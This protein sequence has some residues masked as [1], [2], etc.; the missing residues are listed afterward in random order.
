[1]S[2]EKF[3]TLNGELDPL[4]RQLCNHPVYSHLNDVD[5]LKCFMEQ[6]V[7]AV[8]DFMSLLKALQQEYCRSQVPWVPHENRLAARLVNEIVLAEESDEGPD[9]EYVSHFGM[10]CQAMK[11]V[12]ASTQWID[13]LLQVV[14]RGKPIEV[15][16]HEV[17]LP[18]HVRDFVTQTFAV[19]EQGQPEE[20]AAVFLFGREDLIPDMFNQIVG[21][22]NRELKGQLSC[23]EYYLNRHIELDGETHGPMA[24]LLLTSLCGQDEAKWNR[25]GEAAR[26]TLL[27][28]ISLWDGIA[29]SIAG[30]KLV[31]V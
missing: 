12:G 3:K 29:A 13:Q 18:E 4:R 23:F 5:V 21:N 25:A 6:H 22:L 11:Q 27:Q 19:I 8:W 10:Y 1:M 2:Q 7:F 9:G 31:T 15:C 14:G 26:K 30:D 16:L 28:R 24:A 20:M 17:D